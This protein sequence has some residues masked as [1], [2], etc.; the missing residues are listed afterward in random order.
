LNL[1][2][3]P[4]PVQSAA[5]RRTKRPQRRRKSRGVRWSWRARLLLLAILAACA[6]IGWAILARITAPQGNTAQARFDAI[7]VLGGSLDSDGNLKAAALARTTEGVREYERGIAPRLILTGGLDHGA[8]V[9]AAAM[10]RAAQAQGVPPS[11]IFLEPHASDTIQNACFSARLMK[12]HGWSSAEVV[13]SPSHLPRAALVFSK[14]PIQWRAHAAPPMEQPS[15]AG[16]FATQTLEVL[17]TMRYLL[18][19]TWAEPCSP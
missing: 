3:Q 1:E 2:T 17:K 7:L 6:A 16:N 9:E 12:E 18:Y 4:L 14:T 15:P 19:A 11:A 10:A 13:T 8:F 5:V